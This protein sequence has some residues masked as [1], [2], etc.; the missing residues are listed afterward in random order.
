[1]IGSTEIS[2]TR[3]AYSHDPLRFAF[4]S[5]R[6]ALI[7]RAEGI[8]VD[9]PQS[10]SPLKP[11]YEAPIKRLFSKWMPPGAHMAPLVLFRTLAI[12]DELAARMRPL[13]VGILHS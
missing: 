5:V 10:D 9:A 13:G 2:A 4:Q 1:M 3:A 7:I 12:H 8:D 6:S 11:P